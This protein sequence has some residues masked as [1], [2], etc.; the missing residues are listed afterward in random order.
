MA[1]GRKANSPGTTRNPRSTTD[2]PHRPTS[3]GNR[4]F[5]RANAENIWFL[6]I[7]Y[8]LAA[9]VG[10]I[11]A[12][13][14]VIPYERAVRY[15]F[16]RAIADSGILEIVSQV[17]VIN[18]VVGVSAITAFWIIGIVFWGLL[19][20]M[21]LFEKFL[22]RNR[23]FMQYTI[24]DA[25]SHQKYVIHEDDDPLLV[26]MKQFYN[27]LPLLTMRDARKA[28]LIAYTI[29]LCVCIWIYPPIENGG[30]GELMIVLLTGQWSLIAWANVVALFATLF[31]VEIVVDILFWIS[32]LIRF[33][34]VGMKLQ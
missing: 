25:N 9:S 20:M 31:I 14:N 17:P 13:F 3:R 11:I 26:A 33:V 16:G 21:E 23:A 27:R 22:R 15:L 5:F 4:N 2:I 30:P 34:Q 8:W 7:A 1:F 19:Q 32:D 12:L 6:H 24:D 29:D 28:K 18:A 10:I